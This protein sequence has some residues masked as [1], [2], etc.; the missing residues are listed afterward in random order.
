MKFEAT[1]EVLLPHNDNIH[2]T[3]Y[4]E[5]IKEAIKGLRARL[6]VDF[7]DCKHTQ[8]RILPVKE[9]NQ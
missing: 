9:L 5:T 3:F 8:I 6:E 1:C 2:P 4:G 7:W